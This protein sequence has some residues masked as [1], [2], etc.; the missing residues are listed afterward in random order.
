VTCGRRFLSAARLHVH[1]FVH[2]GE[3]PYICDM[4]LKTYSAPSHLSRHK[5]IVHFKQS[6]DIS[7][8]ETREDVVHPSER[9]FLGEICSKRFSSAFNLRVHSLGHTGERPYICDDCPKKYVDPS[10]LRRH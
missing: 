9:Q 6:S 4:C 5:R 2:T 10:Y 7:K 3:R 1:L 8:K